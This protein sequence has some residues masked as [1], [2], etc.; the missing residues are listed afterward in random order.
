MKRALV[1]FLIVVAAAACQRNDTGTGLPQTRFIE[2][3]VALR[4]AAR[5]TMDPAV[6]AVRKQQILTD[7]GVTEDQLRAYIKTH[8]RDLDHMAAVWESINV[9]LADPTTM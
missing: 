8:E 7:A 2:V 1:L 9:R 4:K 6:F 5:E 3:V